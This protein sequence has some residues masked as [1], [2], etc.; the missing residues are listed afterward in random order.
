MRGYKAGTKPPL[1]LMLHGAGGDGSGTLDKDGW[2][3]KA[4]K[5]GFIA[6]APDGLPARPGG[7]PNFLTNPPLWH[8]G[9][10]R[11]DSP[12]AAIDDVAF[13]RQLLDDLQTKLP[14]DESRVFCA[15]HSNGGDAQA[16]RLATRV[17]RNDSAPSAPWPA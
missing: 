14:F 9:Q 15:G 10:L 3:A 4:D 5:E 13:I 17:G 16:F 12:R 7:R 6:V 1:V 11:P 2:A 8:S